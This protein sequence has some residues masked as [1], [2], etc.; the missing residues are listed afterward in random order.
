MVTRQKQLSVGRSMKL[1]LAGTA[2]AVAALAAL[3]AW[4]RRQRPPTCLRRFGLIGGLAPAST[5]EYYKAI[6]EG[7]RALTSQMPSFAAA[8]GVF[9]QLARF[10]LQAAGGPPQ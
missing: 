2:A 4:R 6:N 8:V 1:V 9:E 5:I 10:L 7:V 3:L